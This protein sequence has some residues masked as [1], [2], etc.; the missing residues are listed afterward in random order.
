MRHPVFRIAMGTALLVGSYAMYGPILAVL[1]QQRGLGPV[2]IGAFAMIGFTCI[3]LLIPVMPQWLAHIGEVPA[4]RIGMGLQLVATLG[5][6]VFEPVLAWCAFAVL[7]AVGSAAVWNAT[8]SLIARHSPPDRR[9]QITGLYQTMLGAAM[10]LGPFVP[11]LLQTTAKQTLALASA[12]QAAGALIACWMHHGDAAALQGPAGHPPADA[13]HTAQSTWGAVKMVPALVAIA[14]A[15]GVFESGLSSLSAAQGAVM[16]L[17]IAAAASVVGVLGLGSFLF[18]WPA[19]LLA[20]RVA[21]GR[22]FGAAGAVLLLASLAF[23]AI[24]QMQ[25]LLWVSAFFWGGVGGALYTLTMIRVAHQFKGQATSAGTAAMITGYT[26][27][28]AVGPLVSGASLQVFGAP[29]MAAWLALLALS[30]VY[31]SRRVA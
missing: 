28:G 17:N 10:T 11:G 6:A 2:A 31:F 25:S 7:G 14:F 16:G 30:V 26:L 12:V 3:A 21:P 18:Q 15:G 8:E 13:V 9:G 27:G 4:H 1:L 20:D 29:G 5:F 19:G 24:G 23:G 22:L